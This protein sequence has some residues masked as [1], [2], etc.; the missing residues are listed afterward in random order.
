VIDLDSATKVKDI[1]VGGHL[2]HPEAIALDPRADRA[3]VAIANEDRVAV[4]DTRT[5]TLARSLSTARAEGQGTSPVDLAVTPDGAQ[6]YVAEAGADELAAFRLS[7]FALVGRVPI[8]STPQGVAVAPAS[9]N[10]CDVA[11]VRRRAK[12]RVRHRAR[13]RRVQRRRPAFTARVRRKPVRRQAARPRCSKLVWL[14]ARGF[15]V[16]ANPRGPNPYVIND[17]NTSSQNYLPVLIRGMAGVLDLPNEARLRSLTPLATAQVRPS[18]AQPPP[19]GTPLR[20]GGPIKHVFYIVKENRT[21]DQVLGDDSRGDGD[22]SL[23][24]FGRQV[25]PN[26]HALS[27]RFPLLDHVYANSEAS[28]DGH[29]WTAAGKVSDYVEKNWNQNYGHRGRPYDFGAFSVTWPQNQFL[30]DQAERQGIPWYDYGEALGRVVPNFGAN[31]DLVTPTVPFLDKDRTPDEDAAVVANSAKTDLG[32]PIGCYPNDAYTLKNAITRN[33]VSD[34]S[35]PA[36]WPTNSESRFDCFRARFQAQLATGQVP[37]FNYLVMTLDHTG[38]GS[39]GDYT[40]RAYVANNDYGVG[41][42]V[43]LISH[44]PIWS[45]SAIFVVEDDSQDGADHVDAHRIPAYV[46]SP[47]A[48]QGA[49]VSTRY[50]FLSVIRSMQLI[51]G[52]RSLGLADAQATP[53]YDAFQSTP[54]NDAPYTAIP[55]TWNV[56]EK[57]VAGAAAARMSRGLNFNQVDRVSQRKLDRIIWKTVHGDRAE[58]PRPRRGSASKR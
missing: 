51:T 54:A 9:A 12:R 11:A 16:G 42:V 35:T 56:N 52:M 46:I 49:V 33:Q 22:P 58:P 3:Y 19:A 25:T 40:P 31:T 1:Q 21:Y 37:A 18:N 24:I 39:A 26:A 13:P 4:I 7:D 14:S 5:M 29:F 20:P 27:Q 10:E 38:G 17:N 34:S 43:E 36:G 47:Y 30:I 53:M 8:A 15:D 2:S 32:P 48:R 44:S 23:A 28:I 45:S 41:Q 50:D 6:L 57:N 55:P